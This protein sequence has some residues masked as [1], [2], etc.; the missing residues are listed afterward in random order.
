MAYVLFTVA[1]IVFTLL[2]VA[3]AVVSGIQASPLQPPHEARMREI[4]A[5]TRDAF[6][7]L[8]T[9]IAYLRDAVRANSTTPLN[10]GLDVEM[11]NVSSML[12]SSISRIDTSLRSWDEATPAGDVRWRL[13][14]CAGLAVLAAFAQFFALG[15]Q[16]AWSRQTSQVPRQSLVSRESPDPTSDQCA[17]RQSPPQSCPNVRYD[18]KRPDHAGRNV[19]GDG[20]K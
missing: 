17:T 16:V 7:Q 20:G 13:L 2:C 4:S 14:V 19:A 1:G 18:P 9:S 5:A 10:P 6:W 15:H 11:D 12:N 3:A 8:K